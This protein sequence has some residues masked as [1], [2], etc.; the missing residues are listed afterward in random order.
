MQARQGLR[1]LLRNEGSF[2]LLRVAAPGALQQAPSFAKT[3]S[4]G[5]RNEAN[6]NSNNNVNVKEEDILV[7]IKNGVRT[8]RLNRPEKRN[9][10]TFGMLQTLVTSLNEGSEDEGTRVIVL[11]GTGDYFTGGMD[12]GGRKK[13]EGSQDENNQNK[14]ETSATSAKDINN[15]VQPVQKV[16]EEVRKAK[17]AKFVHS[18]IDCK[19]PLIALVNG[20]AVGLGVTMLGLFDTVYASDKAMFITSFIRWGLPPELCSTYT[21]PR[22]MGYARANKI[23]LEDKKITAKEALDAGLVSRIFPHETFPQETS[24]IVESY[25]MLP[26]KSLMYTKALV[27]GSQVELLKSVSDKEQ[28][29]FNPEVAREIKRKFME[30]QLKA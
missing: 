13:S 11:T 5:S 8:I 24:K 30:R 6:K 21:F 12:L 1:F 2:K 23:L 15:N 16:P 27:R 18:F 7:S 4:T 17:A 29:F 20:P 25:G 14:T 10:L 9:A 26:L 3:I 19:K 28:S 22:I